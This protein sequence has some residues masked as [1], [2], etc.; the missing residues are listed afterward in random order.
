MKEI[1]ALCGS[2]F[3]FTEILLYVLVQMM[4][5]VP[6]AENAYGSIEPA[7]GENT[8]SPQASAALSRVLADMNSVML[9]EILG[10][11]FNICLS[12]RNGAIE[13]A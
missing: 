9:R 3:K 1:D 5:I 8:F 10:E 11:R 13:E 6:I 7:S 4:E 2:L 12:H